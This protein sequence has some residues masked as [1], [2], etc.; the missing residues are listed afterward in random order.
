VHGIPL[1]LLLD[2]EG[3]RV[4]KVR[5]GEETKRAVFI[6]MTGGLEE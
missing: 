3:R 6:P 1:D 2:D 5:F 4:K